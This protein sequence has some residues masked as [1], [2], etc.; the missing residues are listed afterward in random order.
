MSK[1][2]HVNSL[3]ESS[4]EEKCRHVDK[5]TPKHVEVISN[6]LYENARDLQDS[7]DEM[8]GTRSK[9]NP[10]S[11]IT[12]IA[13]NDMKSEI[14]S[15]DSIISRLCNPEQLNE[16]EWKIIFIELVKADNKD[17][18][19]YLGG[20]AKEDSFYDEIRET[21]AWVGLVSGV[22]TSQGGN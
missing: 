16:S 14:E 13:I 12:K 15:Y 8:C 1:L 18:L 4:W 10:F 9:V 17:F 7:L 6:V 20:E 5:I 2:I 3:G 21:T 19:V 22:P 11:E